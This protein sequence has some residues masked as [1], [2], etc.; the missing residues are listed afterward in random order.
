MIISVGN[1][2]MRKRKKL[3]EGKFNQITKGIIEG[4]K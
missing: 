3:I 4:S 2:H 1:A